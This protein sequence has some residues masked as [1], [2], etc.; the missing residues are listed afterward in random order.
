MTGSK[1]STYIAASEVATL[2]HELRDHTVERGASVSEALLASAQSAEVL[3]GL[4]NNIIVQSEVDAAGLFCSAITR[5]HVGN[6]IAED[7]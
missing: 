6:A 5:Q 7:R 2:Q 1:K 4:G 3:G